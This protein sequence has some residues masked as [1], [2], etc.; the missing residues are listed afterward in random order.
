MCAS[1]FP[2]KLINSSSPLFW[3]ETHPVLPCPSLAG[4]VGGP[5]DEGPPRPSVRAGGPPTQ[6]E[7]ELCVSF[8]YD[9]LTV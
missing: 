5:E 7:S 3:F 8:A 1:V 2:G 6:V 9:S 4:R